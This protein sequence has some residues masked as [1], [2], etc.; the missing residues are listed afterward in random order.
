MTP[1]C[2]QDFHIGDE[3]RR[4]SDGRLAWIF[5]IKPAGINAAIYVKWIDT[6]ELEAFFNQIKCDVFEKT[7]N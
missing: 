6:G 7:G 1:C 4:T 3:V 2:T 5:R